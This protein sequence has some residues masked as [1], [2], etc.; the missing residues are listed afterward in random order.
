MTGATA[1]EKPTEVID[2][3]SGQGRAHGP[4]HALSAKGLELRRIAFSRLI[5]MQ[6]IIQTPARL[7]NNA[8]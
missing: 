5:A 4:D 3:L 6:G 1:T 8:L 2:R 7:P